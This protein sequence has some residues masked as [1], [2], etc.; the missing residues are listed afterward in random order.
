MGV[1]FEDGTNETHTQVFVAAD[2][3]EFWLFA[4][5]THKRVQYF[6]IYLGATP[7]SYIRIDDVVGIVSAYRTYKRANGSCATNGNNTIIAA[8]AG[9]KI[10]VYDYSLQAEGTVVATFQNGAG[11]AQIG[12]RWSFQARE[13]KLKH[14]IPPLSPHDFETAA[15]TLLNLSLSA[16]IQ[17][18]YEIIYTD[19]DAA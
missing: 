12:Q 15:T 17:V 11:G 7:A 16:A 9:M 13:G 6:Y 18:N 3:Y 10:K 4:P 19:T 1:I 2:T 8:V 14:G 5:T